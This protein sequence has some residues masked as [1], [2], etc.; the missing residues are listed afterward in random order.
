MKSIFKINSLILISALFVGLSSC[1]RTQRTGWEFSP[2]MYDDVGYEALTQI[3]KNNINPGGMNM[4]LP[5]E[6]TISRR[7]YNTSFKVNDSTVIND[8]MIYDLTKNDVA[9]A[10]SLVNPVPLTEETLAE[11]EVLYQRY[12][13]HCH[14]K[15]GA[16]D[17]KVSDIY[18]GVPTYTSDAIKDLTAGR[19]F[20][21]ITFGYGRM[22]P[23]GS[24]V[25]PE[26]RWKI[27]HYVQKLQQED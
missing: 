27:V 13:A 6:G 5:V 3:E 23:H 25:D 20:F 7:N 17:G 19:I 14:G 18:A 15:T 2:N 22:W 9:K 8:L 16:A 1:D 24:Q 11:G 21:D 26:E 4:R 10:D 12:C